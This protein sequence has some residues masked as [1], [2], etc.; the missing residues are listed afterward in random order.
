MGGEFITSTKSTDAIIISYLKGEATAQQ[1]ADLL[2]W[3][4]ESEE[5]KRYFRSLKDVY[6]LGQ[7]DRYLQE[8][9]TDRQWHLLK[10]KIAPENKNT[11]FRK[12]TIRKAVSYAA[13]LLIGFLCVH[14]YDN[15]LNVAEI[16]ETTKIETGVGQQSKVTLPDGSI[17]WLNSC[18]T[19]QYN[20]F[21]GKE[22]RIVDLNGEAYFEIEPDK[23]KPFIVKTDNFDYKVTG[24]AF[25]IYSYKEDDITSISLTEG[26]VEVENDRYN[27]LLKKGETLEYNKVTGSLISRSDRVN[28][29]TSWRR[30]EIVFDKISFGN[31]TKRLERIY[32][33]SFVFTNQKAKDKIFYGTFYNYESL[34][35][36]LKVINTSIP[37][38]Y[39]IEYNRVYIN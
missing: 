37:I 33:V 31:L 3:L 30:G 29:Y 2:V 16:A 1:Q 10:Q 5:N 19:L 24:T 18:S 32:N 27:R 8:S 17:V 36:V 23:R 7:V 9:D 4:Q 6:D 15:T 12:P 35:T 22:N 14:L 20:S 38:N 34:E 13:V 11:I 21:T 39:S 26:S 25:N 28:L